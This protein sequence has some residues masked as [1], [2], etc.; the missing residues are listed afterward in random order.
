MFAVKLLWMLSRDIPENSAHAAAE[1]V[2]VVVELDPL[3]RFA[4]RYSAASDHGPFNTISTP[5]PA[6][7]PV[8]VKFLPVAGRDGATPAMVDKAWA[9]ITNRLSKAPNEWAKI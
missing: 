2:Q 6:T 8:E 9:Y 7:Q 5:P 3:P 1:P 4:W